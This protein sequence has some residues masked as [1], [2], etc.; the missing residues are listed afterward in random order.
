VDHQQKSLTNLGFT[1]VIPFIIGA[2]VMWLSPLIIPAWIALNIHTIVLAYGGIITA[3][4]AGSGA[5]VILGGKIN[6]PLWPGMTAALLAWIAILPGGFLIFTIPAAWRY[7][8][9]IF[10]LT[11]LLFRDLRAVERNQLPKWYGDLRVRLTLW[12]SASL[13]LIAVRLALMGHA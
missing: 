7:G 6:E 12:A 8:I 11:Y 13:F 3:Y 10:V 4:M 2:V 9:I 1:G 5:G